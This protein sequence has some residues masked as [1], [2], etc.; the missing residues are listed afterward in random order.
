[1]SYFNNII[2]FSKK[3]KNIENL[4]YDIL[5]MFPVNTTYEE[6]ERYNIV[7]KKVSIA[8]RTC[9]LLTNL[10]LYWNFKDNIPGKKYSQE[11]WEDMLSYGFK[12]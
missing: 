2:E 6:L 12:F 7:L 3:L 1:M 9:F 5:T 11:L 10:P 4:F 8:E